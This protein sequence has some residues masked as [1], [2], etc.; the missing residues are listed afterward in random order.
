MKNP[1]E[2]QQEWFASWFDSP[3]Y[4][5]LYQHRDYR[6]AESFIDHLLGHLQP[7]AGSHFLDLAC[8]RGRHSIYIH[9]AGHRVTGIDL[10]PESIA[11]ARQQAAPGLDFLVGDMRDAIPGQYDYIFNLFTSFGY[12]DDPAD[13]LK[14]LGNVHAALKPGGILVL[15]FM[16]AAKAIADLVPA[17]SKELSGIRFHIR[18]SVTRKGDAQHIVKDILVEDGGQR[19]EFQER[20]Q[21]LMDQDFGRMFAEAGL[22]RF[23]IWGDYEGD[24]FDPATSPRLISF[25]RLK[26]D[27]QS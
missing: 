13:N 3:F 6:E 27:H 7:P 12:F 11:E 22:E 8:G 16:N 9:R 25:C 1:A 19:Y 21:A 14:V 15:D 20:V 24:P 17:E 26:A 2:G 4:P 5:I 23:Q 10:S 18:K